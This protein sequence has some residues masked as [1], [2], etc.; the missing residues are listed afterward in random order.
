MM[1]K[2]ALSQLSARTKCVSK[3]GGGSRSCAV[4]AHV[5]ARRSTCVH[6]TCHDASRR[7]CAS[8][9]SASHT[10]LLQSV[11][12]K[13]KEAPALHISRVP[14]PRRSAAALEGAARRTRGPLRYVSQ[15]H[16]HIACLH[17]GVP[18]ASGR[19]DPPARR[20]CFQKMPST[21]VQNRTKTIYLTDSNEFV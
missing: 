13:P 8:A 18:A 17:Q 11:Q 6:S 21:M 1:S 7:T 14:D 16:D 3:V 19:R 20:T 15:M 5:H 9:S 2:L 4:H 10:Y 12:T